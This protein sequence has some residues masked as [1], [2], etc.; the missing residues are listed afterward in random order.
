MPSEEPL[1]GQW[2]ATV[3]G[4]VEHHFDNAVD[5]TIYVDNVAPVQ[6]QPP[7]NGGSDLFD[8][9]VFAFDRAALDDILD[10]CSQ[11]C[12]VLQIEA[13]GVHSSQ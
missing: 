12:F 10:G 3:T 2:P 5:V 13:N 6:P 7:S 8:I 4:G 1:G 9:Q 11:M